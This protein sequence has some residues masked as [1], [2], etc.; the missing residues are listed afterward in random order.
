VESVIAWD[1]QHAE[2]AEPAH[3]ALVGG[4]LQ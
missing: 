3:V 2:N 1:E 4:D